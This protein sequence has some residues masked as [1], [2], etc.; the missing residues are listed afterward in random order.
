MRDNW[1]TEELRYNIMAAIIAQ[2]SLAARE[3]KVIQIVF[4]FGVNM[5]RYNKIF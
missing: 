3:R 1:Y 2:I 5:F 4:N